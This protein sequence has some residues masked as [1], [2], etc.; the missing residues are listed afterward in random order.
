MLAFA[1]LLSTNTVTAQHVGT[2]FT[3]NVS[4][5]VKGGVSTQML[6]MYKGVSPVVGIQVEKYVNPWLGFAVDANTL[7][8]NPY[9]SGNPHTMFDVVNVNMLTKVNLLNTLNYNG[10]RKFFEPVIFAGIGWG[11]RTCK[12]YATATHE[13]G[14]NYMVSKAGVELNF[15]LDKEKAW[16]VRVSPAVVWGPV[17]CGRLDART[18]GFEITAGVTYHFKGSNGKRYFTNARLYDYEEVNRLNETIEALNK[19]N[20]MNKRVIAGQRNELHKQAEMLKRN[21]EV[22]RDTVYMDLNSKVFFNAGSAVITSK[23]AVRDLA[24]QLKENANYIVTG[25]AS[26]D[27]ATK[28]NQ[29]LSEKRA[30]NLMNMLI[31]YGVNPDNI[32]FV[33]KGETT[34]FSTTDRARNRVAVVDI[35]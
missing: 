5:E 26:K 24:S 6:D 33:G 32:T 31:E 29:T 25:Y 13:H 17:E 34:E 16:G 8:S 22:K 2:R 21:H 11:H 4:I 18:G 23:A 30:K 27:G 7:I 15:N 20:A 10:E 1:M 19:E 14:K 12:D 3:D 9:G 28:Y 35:K